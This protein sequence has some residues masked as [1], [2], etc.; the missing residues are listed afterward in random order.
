MKVKNIRETVRKMKLPE[1]D[2]AWHCFVTLDIFTGR[3]DATVE[4]SFT[5]PA[6]YITDSDC[7][8]IGSHIYEWLDDNGLSIN[9]KNVR[10]F[11]ETVHTF[12]EL[13]VDGE[14]KGYFFDW[15]TANKYASYSLMDTQDVKIVEIPVT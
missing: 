6:F 3:L 1:T 12:Y 11:F 2:S 5:R 7:I 4:Y 14:S 8:E 15:Y 9:E 13:Q 10:S